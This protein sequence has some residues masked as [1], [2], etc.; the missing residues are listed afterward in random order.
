ME[1]SARLY[2]SDLAPSTERNWGAYSITSVWFATLHNIGQYTL[3][4]DYF[5][6]VF[7]P[8]KYSLGS[9]SDSVCHGLAPK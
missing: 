5:S 9:S 7:Q 8:G 2:N 1:T 3:P 4:L 6:W